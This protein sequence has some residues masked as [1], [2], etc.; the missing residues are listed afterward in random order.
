MADVSDFLLLMYLGN[1]LPGAVRVEAAEGGLPA[2]MSETLD[3]ARRREG[4]RKISFSLS[5]VQLKFSVRERDGEYVIPEPGELGDWIVKL[6]SDVYQEMPANEYAMM[7]WASSVGISVP[8]HRLIDLSQL[9]GLPDD[10]VNPGELGFAVRRFDRT[11]AGRVHQ[12]DFAQ[13]LDAI[14]SAKDRGSQDDIGR[15]LMQECPEADFWEYLKR[16]VFCVVA[17]NTDE[18][19]KNWSLQ[20]PGGHSARLSPAYDLVAVTAYPRFRRDTLTLSIASLNDTQLLRSA[21]FRI[22]AERLGA[23]GDKATSVVQETADQLRRSWPDVSNDA[24]T[25]EFV[26]QH[27]GERIARLPLMAE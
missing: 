22:F 11:Q 14:P 6:P 17:G 24:R 13:V 25:P 27:I 18:H 16:L 19:L 20:Y 5:G 12:E 21:Q 15:V 8:E 1:D 9:K 4:R 7:T 23:D 2:R 26:R 3:A 10:L